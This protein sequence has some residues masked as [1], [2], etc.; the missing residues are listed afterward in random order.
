MS[1]VLLVSVFVGGGFLINPASGATG[2]SVSVLLRFGQDPHNTCSGRRMLWGKPALPC[3][4]L[5]VGKPS[6]IIGVCMLKSVQTK[7]AASVIYLKH[8]SLSLQPMLNKC[9]FNDS[10]D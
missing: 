8:Y 10:Y 2:N 7:I 4:T 3:F 6:A 9:T 5:Y 1:R